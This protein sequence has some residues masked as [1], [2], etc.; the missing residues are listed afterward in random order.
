MRLIRGTVTR[1]GRTALWVALPPLGLCR[2]IAHGNQKRQRQQTRKITKAI[3]QAPPPTPE[4][5]ANR[6]IPTVP[7]QQWGVIPTVQQQWV[8]PAVRQPAITAPPRQPRRTTP[9]PIGALIDGFQ[10]IPGRR[11]K[12]WVLVLAALAVMGTG[13]WGMAAVIVVG[14]AVLA[15]IGASQ[16]PQ[17]PPA[18]APPDEADPTSER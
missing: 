2:S 14:V 13:G 6:G 11:A 18:A 1:A 10:A 12:W 7:P 15:T 9:G 17:G 16:H 4:P 5:I 3:R 8:A